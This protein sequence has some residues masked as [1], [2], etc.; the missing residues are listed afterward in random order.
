MNLAFDLG[1]DSSIVVELVMDSLFVIDIISNF[2]TAFTI[3]RGRRA[4]QVRPSGRRRHTARNALCI[5]SW[6]RGAAR[7]RS[8]T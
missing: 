8:S 1:L 2:F 5:G 7:S 6:K 4:G 3:V